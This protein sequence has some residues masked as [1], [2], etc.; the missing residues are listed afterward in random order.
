MLLPED[1][2]AACRMLRPQDMLLCCA[3]FPIK[4]FGMWHKTF[5]RHCQHLKTPQQQRTTSP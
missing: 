5:H 3:A 4:A 1:A 2:G